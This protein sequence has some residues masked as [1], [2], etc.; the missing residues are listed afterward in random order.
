MPNS[1]LHTAISVPRFSRYLA[2]CNN[3]QER[4]EMLYR[5]NL[6]LSEKMYSIIG[7]FEIILRNSIDRHFIPLKGNTWLEDAVV[8]GGYFDISPGCE[9]SFHAVQEA[10]YKLGLDYTHDRLIAKLTFGFWAYQFGAKE[11]A[12]SGSTLLEIFPNRPKGTRQKMIFQDLIRINDI[13]NRIAHY[14]P[15]CFDK[16]TGTVSTV[17]VEKRY[18]LIIQ[19]LN[20]LGCNPQKILHGIDGVQKAIDS[21][22]AI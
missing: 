16:K 1:Q 6:R 13:R 21:V 3:S 22:N 10:I 18:N 4:A 19:L 15:I 5:A 12:A 17:L 7:L 14:E 2:A 8:E 20:W 9:D 11:F